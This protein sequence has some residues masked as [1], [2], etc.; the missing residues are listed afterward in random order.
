MTTT[1]PPTTGGTT[2]WPKVKVILIVN[3][4]TEEALETIVETTTEEGVVTIQ[5]KPLR[6][7]K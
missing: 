5:R 6:M 4:L 1:A 3:T 7:E 2:K